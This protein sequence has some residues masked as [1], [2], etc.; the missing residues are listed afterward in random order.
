MAPKLVASGRVEGLHVTP[1]GE[2]VGQPVPKL[3]ALVG[4][5]IRGDRH[6][7]DRLSD[8]RDVLAAK[9]GHGR[10]LSEISTFM[11]LPSQLPGG[12]LGANL[13][14]DGIAEMTQLPSG[15]ILTFSGGGAG[16]QPRK[17]RL[18]VA[19]ANEPC[20]VPDENI[21][22]YYAADPLVDQGGFRPKQG[23]VA[24]ARARRGLVGFV[25]MSG[26]IKVG[27]EVQ[28]WQF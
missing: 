22:R 6:S 28:A 8:V 25:D 2:T 14:I 17:A 21:Q 12:L 20:Q 7:G 18:W 9:L 26:I 19:R 15:T 1:F 23:F 16:K 27:D 4:H 3:Q 24:A 5:G 10:E 13:V 11:G